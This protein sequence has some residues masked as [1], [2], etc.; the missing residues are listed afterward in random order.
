MTHK[1]NLQHTVSSYGISFLLLF[2][3]QTIFILLKSAT[4]H[5]A[6]AYP[7]NVLYSLLKTA[8]DFHVSHKHIWIQH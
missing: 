7:R 1:I 8:G 5:Q 4:C 2:V 6:V 3:L